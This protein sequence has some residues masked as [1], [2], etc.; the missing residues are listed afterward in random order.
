VSA[1]DEP[2]RPGT[3]DSLRT[4]REH[5]DALLDVYKRLGS[6]CDALDRIESEL[7]GVTRETRAARTEAERATAAAREA[8]QK[9]RF[10]DKRIDSLVSRVQ[11]VENATR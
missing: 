5:T 2:T 9:A 10:S 1:D 7:R 4:Q 3:P 8:A 11:T 6:I